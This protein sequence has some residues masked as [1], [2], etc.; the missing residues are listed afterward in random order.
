M[1]ATPASGALCAVC[2]ED[3]D[4]P[5]KISCDH[6]FCR[7]CISRTLVSRD[8]CPVCSKTP[9]PLRP[10]IPVNSTPFSEI[11]E[12]LFCY[13]YQASAIAIGL[14]IICTLMTGLTRLFG[15]LTLEDYRWIVTMS[16]CRKPFINAIFDLLCSFP[17][18][19]RLTQSE[20]SSLA[21]TFGY[22]CVSTVLFASEESWI[23]W[24]AYGSF[25]LQVVYTLIYW[26]CES[27][28]RAH[29]GCPI[30]D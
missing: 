2:R 15:P 28:V 24:V 26:P 16:F 14:L 13:L 12:D 17:Y 4:R 5:H 7:D 21:S 8:S 22:T 23:W 10:R 30:V 29:H 11:L 27:A 9:S 20:T 19:K 1:P 6:V 18:Y 25:G 3:F